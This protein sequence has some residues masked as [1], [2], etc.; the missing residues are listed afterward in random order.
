MRTH[1]AGAIA[2]DKNDIYL[3][4]GSADF[5]DSVY[6]FKQESKSS[7]IETSQVAAPSFMRTGE[8]RAQGVEVQYVD[9][10]NDGRQDLILR[11]TDPALEHTYPPVV[12]LRNVQEDASS[13]CVFFNNDKNPFG[14]KAT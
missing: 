2:I 14:A 1:P 12:F 3:I 6:A 10:D 8:G 13:A 4:L 11:N 9:I 5:S 7:F